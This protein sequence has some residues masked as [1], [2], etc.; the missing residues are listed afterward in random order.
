MSLGDR[1]NAFKKTLQK[2]N[3]GPSVEELREQ[4]VRRLEEQLLRRLPPDYRDFLLT[5]FEQQP[6]LNTVD[7][8]AD[9]FKSKVLYSFSIRK[10][11]TINPN[12]K[13]D[14]LYNYNKYESKAPEPDLLPIAFDQFRNIMAITLN[15]GKIYFWD[16]LLKVE[17][18][19]RAQ[20][21]PEFKRSDKLYF[22]ADS[23]EQFQDRLY[24]KNR[25]T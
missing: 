16:Y 3:F 10:Y 2:L 23:F 24:K 22:V 1:L 13:D 11:L 8:Y 17:D 14:I 25:F 19:M 5:D 18:E 9:E 4:Q 21:D 6:F 7:V 15:D 12:G 20:V